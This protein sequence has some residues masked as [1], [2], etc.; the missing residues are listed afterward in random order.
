MCFRDNREHFV[1]AASYLNPLVKQRAVDC[2]RNRVCYRWRI[3][4]PLA[5]DD[6]PLVNKLRYVEFQ[7]WPEM[8]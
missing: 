5:T 2:Y 8:S 3:K 7:E 6:K 4:R 1:H